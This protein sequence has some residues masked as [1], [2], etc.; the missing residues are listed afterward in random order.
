M[1]FLKYIIVLLVI[2]AA[3]AI[4]IY[5]AGTNIASEKVVE[6]AT[7]EL[8]ATG[9]MDSIKTYVEND[10]ELKGYIEEAK[11]ADESQ[12]PFQTKGEATRVLIQKVGIGELQSLQQGVQN[13]TI[14]QQEAIAKL[15][16]ELSE[17]EMLALKVIAYKE[18]YKNE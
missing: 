2:I 4:A 1:K 10:P 13:G 3:G 11:S 9:Q 14:S 16:G 12:L 17:E 5:Y 6:D 18:L 7:A 15:E 8:E